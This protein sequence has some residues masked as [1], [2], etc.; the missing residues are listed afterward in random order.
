MDSSSSIL[1]QAC[2]LALAAVAAAAVGVPTTVRAENEPGREALEEIV[3]TA[4]RREQNLT[5][6][7]IAMQAFTEADIQR[8][9][10]GGLDTLVNQIPSASINLNW[11]PAITVVQLRGSGATGQLGQSAVGFYLDE[12]PFLLPKNQAA[13]PAGMFDVQ[14]VEV[15]RGPQGTLWGQG[16]MGGTIR[17]ITP[18]PDP[19]GFDAKLRGDLHGLSNG[20]TGGSFDAML[21]VP[22]VADSV[23]LRMSGGYQKFAGWFESPDFPGKHN[24][25]DGDEWNLRTSLG[26]RAS[27]SIDVNLQYLH[28]KVDQD[29]ANFGSS[30]DPPAITGTGGFRQYSGA[31]T[32][33][34]AA[35]VHWDL[36]FARLVSATSYMQHSIPFGTGLA[37]LGGGH[38]A[39]E[40][41]SRSFSQE[42][43]LVSAGDQPL[44]WIAGV[45]Y[46]KGSADSSSEVAWNVPAIQGLAGSVSDSSTDTKSTA[47]YGELSY[48][49]MGGKLVPLVGLRY[50]HDDRGFFEQALLYQGT[51]GERLD[52]PYDAKDSFKSWNPRFNLSYYPNGHT[53]LYLNAAKGFRSGTQQ[54]VV[55]VLIAGLDGVNTNRSVDADSVWSYEAGGK[56]TLLG[57]RLLVEAALF[58]EEFSDLQSLYVTSLGTT[59]LINLG[60]SRARGVELSVNWRTP[61]EGLDLSMIGNLLDTEWT[62]IAPGKAAATGISVGDPVPFSPKW[63]YTVAADYARPVGRVTAFGRLSYTGRGPQLSFADEES[64]KIKDLSARVGIRRDRYEVTLYAENLLDKL[65]PVLTSGGLQ[66]SYTPRKIGIQFSLGM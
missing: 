12:V 3:V 30:L 42:L 35:T 24:I 23:A 38:Y 8:L 49:F 17:Y 7:P 59:A 2:R 64:G 33:L 22:L 63:G 4:Q 61:L 54:G 29:F 57:G 53:T 37:I 50:F 10:V 13:P 25:N 15:L 21:N 51:P 60:D 39:V 26:W 62:A 6:V 56:F 28:M 52:A 48:G 11:G 19:S 66:F 20:G 41:D 31:E 46:N 9:G 65:G 44:Q 55:A 27:D 18:E 1:K 36:G 43:R 34:Y 47:L 14:R 16:S 58:Q 32:D 5:E 40:E 45:F